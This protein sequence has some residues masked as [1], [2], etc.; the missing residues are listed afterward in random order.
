MHHGQRVEKGPAGSP[1]HSPGRGPVDVTDAATAPP[2][3]ATLALC[4]EDAFD[5][6]TVR[7]GEVPL[8]RAHVIVNLLR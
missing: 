5:V 3:S 7:G 1:Y 8:G 6:A 2:A 4:G